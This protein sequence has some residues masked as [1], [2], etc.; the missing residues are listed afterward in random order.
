MNALCLCENADFGPDRRA[1]CDLRDCPGRTHKLG[2]AVLEASLKL[3]VEDEGG[4]RREP[5]KPMELLVRGSPGKLSSGASVSFPATQF[6]LK[7][8]RAYAEFFGTREATARSL[9]AT[10]VDKLR[11][12]V[13]GR[14]GLGPADS[15]QRSSRSEGARLQQHR[16]TVLK[17]VEAVASGDRR[18]ILGGKLDTASEEPTSWSLH[19]AAAAAA[20]MAQNQAVAPTDPCSLL[21]IPLSSSS[22][23][24]SS[25][26]GSNPPHSPAA[27]ALASWALSSLLR[28]NLMID[29]AE[30][31]CWCW[32]CRRRPGP[33]DH[34]RI[35]VSEGRRLEVSEGR[36]IEVS[37]GRRF[38]RKW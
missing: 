17:I 1:V 2:R 32:L 6:A 12:S 35:E 3:I 23:S 9:V 22:S 4:R 33:E 18:C 30:Q 26:A 21:Q 31:L 14:P 27:G 5:L 15:R 38:L 29:S 28:V 16:Q 34:R 37:E 19:T 8:Q 7:A 20:A 11:E 25:S 13:V 24:S 10:P 36:R